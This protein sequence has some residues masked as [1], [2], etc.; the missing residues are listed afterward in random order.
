LTH[1]EKP[2]TNFAL[3]NSTWY[4]YNETAL[5]FAGVVG[6]ELTILSKLLSYD[7][8]MELLEDVKEGV[9]G[10]AA[11]VSKFEAGGCTS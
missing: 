9:V 7:S 4:R 2:V 10:A 3:S 1:R 8:P 5:Q 11:A 6:V